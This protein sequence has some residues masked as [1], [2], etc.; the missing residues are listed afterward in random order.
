VQASSAVFAAPALVLLVLAF[1]PPPAHHPTR[2]AET[3]RPADSTI[4]V[5]L[6]D[7]HGLTTLG[8]TVTPVTYQGRRA[9]RVVKANAGDVGNGAAV[10]LIDGIDFAAGTI[11]VLVAGKPAADADPTNR[12]FVGI[13]FRSTPD[14]SRHEV[15][16]LRPTNGRADDQ[17][18]RNHSVQYES[19]P[20]Y[21]WF[22]LR[23]ETPGQYESY[24][25]I[26]PGVWTKMRIVVDGLRARLFVNDALQP[27][28]V[29]NDLKLGATHGRI[30]LWIGFTG[31]D[32]YFSHLTITPAVTR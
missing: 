31:T 19:I 30:G 16:Y 22:R 27:C 3:R 28:L 15:L 20:D 12:G 26:Q 5:P 10:A 21:P 6:E 23:Q 29:V 4:V 18:R 24:V 2:G 9:V 1:A 25:D 32:A 8:A 14:A 13:A 11:E 7:T 17:L